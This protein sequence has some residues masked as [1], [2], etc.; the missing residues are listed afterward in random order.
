MPRSGGIVIVAW[1]EKLKKGKDPGRSVN[2]PWLDLGRSLNCPVTS[3]WQWKQQT[4][5]CLYIVL[6]QLWPSI[7]CFKKKGKF[8]KENYRR[9]P[10][11]KFE[12]TLQ[13]V[14]HM[15]GCHC[16]CTRIV[17]GSMLW[18]HQKRRAIAEQYSFC[19]DK[20]GWCAVVGPKNHTSNIYF[21]MHCNTS[22]NM[23]WSTI[24]LIIIHICAAKR[25][26]IWPIRSHL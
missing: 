18:S 26:Y 10:A 2:C 11:N 13:T 4:W 12:R 25:Y 3:Y 1:N 5:A 17:V 16:E 20:K 19:C 14:F 9:T 15:C 7:W 22:Q 24:E 6:L 21:H 8:H 23:M